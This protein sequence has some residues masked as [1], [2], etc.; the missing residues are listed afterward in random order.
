MKKLLIPF[1]VLFFS[2]NAAKAETYNLDLAKSIEIAKE[3]SYTMKNLVQDFKIAEYNLK[4]ATSSLKTHIDLRFVAPDFNRTVKDFKTD[5]SIT[6]YSSQWLN[7][8]GN[9]IINQPLITGGNVYIRSGVSN[10]DD[11]SLKVRNPSLFTSLGIEQPLTALYG[12]NK[13]KSN[14]KIAKL[15]YESSKKSL[16]R[17]ELNIIY[18]VSNAF[19]SLL[20]SQKRSE[21]ALLDFE[22]QKEANEISQNKYKS[23]LI[24]EVDALQMEVDLAESQN[25]Y[26]LSLVNHGSNLNAFKQLIGI[27][28]NDSI[29]LNSELNYVVVIIDPE[30]AVSLALQ[31]RLEIRE[32]EI[33]IE[34]SRLDVKREKSEGM[35]Q[36]SLNLS[37][38]KSGNS[39]QFINSDMRS[40]LNNSYTDLINRDPDYGIGFTVNI[41]ILDFGE[42]RAK[43]RASQA[44]LEKTILRKDELERDIER[45]VRD[46]V[47]NLN[48]SIKRLQLLEKNKIIAEKSFDITRQRYA[49]GDIDSQ[50]LAL[51]RNRLNNAFNSH[52]NAYIT[53]QLLLAD[54]MRKTFYDFQKNQEIK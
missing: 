50:A 17:E 12:Y 37:L 26:E 36:S 13:V 47:S 49:D 4:A 29:T 54:I 2:L 35:I 20:S 27:N 48:S 51:E 34:Q 24:R 6:Y 16:K 32:Q 43:V 38:G 45:E 7:Y 3:K 46:L 5:T 8:G 41:P 42:N 15:N 28:L 31:N 44:R 9:L 18:Q 1:I 25:N 11:Y 40:S 14:L 23:G 10:T 39:K 53:Y 19:Y 22:R 52:L 21:I 30:K 33:N